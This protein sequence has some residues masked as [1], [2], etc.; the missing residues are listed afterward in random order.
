MR[1]ERFAALTLRTRLLEDTSMLRS[2]HHASF[3]ASKFEGLE[4]RQLMS[5]DVRPID[6]SGNNLTQPD[7]GSTNEALLR[8]AAA[9]YADGISA[10]AGASRPS[11]RAVSN[12]VSTHGEA[13]LPNARNIYAF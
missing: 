3:R 2:H 6:G 7:W 10:P 1:I 12:A 13:D 5:A 8:L 9:Q 4:I 11:A